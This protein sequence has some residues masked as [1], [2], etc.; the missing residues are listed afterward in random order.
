MAKQDDYTRYTVRIPTPLYERVKT[1]AG[2]KSVNAEIIEILS[3]AF[4]KPDP[5]IEEMFGYLDDMSAALHGKPDQ[6]DIEEALS[7]VDMMGTT[8]LQLDDEMRKLR[9]PKGRSMKRDD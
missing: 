7:L 9:E 1:I 5:T 4:P 8:L 3:A 2:D 6:D